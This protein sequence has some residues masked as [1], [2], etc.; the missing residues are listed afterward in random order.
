MSRNLDSKDPDARIE[1]LDLIMP[2][3]S[4]V[5]DA[6]L[7]SQ[8]GQMLFATLDL[9]AVPAVRLKAAEAL[10]SYLSVE[11]T[12]PTDF[13]KAEPYLLDRDA[14]V[15][16][17]LWWVFTDAAI[18][19]SLSKETMNRLLALTAHKDKEIQRQALES[20]VDVWNLHGD[21]ADVSF[22][23][24]DDNTLALCLKWSKSSDRALREVAINGLITAFL[25]TPSP[26]IAVLAAHIDDSSFQIRSTI[27]NF[28][29]EKASQIP[30]LAELN[31]DLIKRF[32][33][34]PPGKDFAGSDPNQ[35]LPEVFRLV[36][37]MAALG[38]LPDDVWDYLLNEAAESESTEMQNELAGLAEGQ[39]PAGTRLMAK[40]RIS[41]GPSYCGR[42]A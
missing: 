4:V 30:G 18:R 26:D 39:G 10:R 34:R 9:E 37:A 21:V 22:S 5:E 15:R 20:A 24:W 19:G 7:R 13:L 29:T 25:R 36:C 8:L 11:G 3:F 16:Q 40:L 23:L 31:P 35:P 33:S 38:P 6:S 2:V 27:L 1:A 32:R 41:Y 14:G 17:H 28:I 12:S 42:A